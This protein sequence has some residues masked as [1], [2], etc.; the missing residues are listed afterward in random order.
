MLTRIYHYTTPAS[1]LAEGVAG[2]IL[3]GGP[4]SVLADESPCPDPGVFQLDVCSV[5]V[6][7]YN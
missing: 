4:A 2:V 1:K 3:S 7:A 5:F 6:T